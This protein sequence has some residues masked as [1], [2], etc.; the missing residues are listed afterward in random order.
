MPRSQD[1]VPWNDFLHFLSTLYTSSSSILPSAQDFILTMVLLWLRSSGMLCSAEWKTVTCLD[2]WTHSMKT[3]QPCII[4][5][6]T[7]KI[8][9]KFTLLKQ[10]IKI[11]ILF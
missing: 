10:H 5:L 1:K 9:L 11:I 7:N 4:R 2:F 8:A 6:C 3:I